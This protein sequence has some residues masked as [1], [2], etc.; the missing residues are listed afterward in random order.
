[1]GSPPTPH[2]RAQGTSGGGWEIAQLTR[3][4]WEAASRA[5]REDTCAVPGSVAQAVWWHRGD[6]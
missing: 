1:M 4:P 5:D 3:G 2:P 6:R